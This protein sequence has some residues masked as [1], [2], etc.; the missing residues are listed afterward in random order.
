MLCVSSCI[1]E[2]P[3][4]VHAFY[5]WKNNQYGFSGQE[6]ALMRSTK[7]EKL[8]VKFFEVSPDLLFTA[9]PTAKTKLK[10]SYDRYERKKDSIQ[11]ELEII[12]TVFIKTEALLNLS[13]P[14]LDSLADNIVFLVGK[15]YQRFE[16]QK[17]TKGWEEIQLDCDWTVNTKENYF[18]LLKKVKEFSKK[19]IS[20]TLRLYPY[21]Y[22]NKMG[23]PPVDRAMLMCYNLISPLGK[24]NKDSIL[25]LKELKAYLKGVENYP[26]ALDIALPIFYWMQLYQNQ[27]FVGLLPPAEVDLL[28]DLKEMK[29]M[30]YRVTKDRVVGTHYL[31]EGDDLKI[32]RLSAEE[33]IG[34]IALIEKY[35]SLSGETTIALFHLD[36]NNLKNFDNES[37]N[38]FYSSFFRK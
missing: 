17:R 12:P 7:T 20:C 1:K 15:Y 38:S 9:I 16:H 11:M 22:A 13:K 19:K 30:W 23:V 25:Y 21:K 10:P 4:A 2:E 26:L 31:R 8:Y 5:Y 3:R 35:I 34:A 27:S 6:E 33:I 14:K 28:S 37:I 36:D 32:E 18:Y 29:P 24:E